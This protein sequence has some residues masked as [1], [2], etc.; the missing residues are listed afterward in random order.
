MAGLCLRLTSALVPYRRAGVEFASHPDR[1]YGLAVM[2]VAELR[3]GAIDELLADPHLDVLAGVPGEGW[4]EIEAVEQIAVMA[5]NL[6]A[7]EAAEAE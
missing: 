5:D 7:V 3:E 1:A 2:R 6:A 4:I